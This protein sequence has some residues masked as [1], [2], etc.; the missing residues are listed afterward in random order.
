MTIPKIPKR[1]VRP[2]KAEIADKE[3][4]FP[5]WGCFCC[6]DTGLIRPKLVKLATEDFDYMTD[7]HPVCNACVKGQKYSGCEEYDHRFTRILC[8]EL[9]RIERENW[10]VTVKE[11]Q[12]ILQ[13]TDLEQKMGMR[14]RNRTEEE[15]DLAALR[16]RE[17]IAVAN[18]D[19]ELSEN[20][21][22][23]QEDLN[24]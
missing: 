8:L 21:R 11:K 16:H 17:A 6:H 22:K 12:R 9:D 5:D 2:E 7:F 4:W 10:A 1:L 19:P 15:E 18:E 14:K 20:K 3:I 23:L 13:T 24:N